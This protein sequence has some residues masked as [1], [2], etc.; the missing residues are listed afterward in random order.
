MVLW[1]IKVCAL[2]E[3]LPLPFETIEQIP[4]V[5]GELLTVLSSG[6]SLCVSFQSR[7]EI[8]NIE[9]KAL[10]FFLGFFFPT[11]K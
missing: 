10:E 7:W 11:P 9:L 2:S 1:N 3:V 6:F 8:L 5:Q 4:L